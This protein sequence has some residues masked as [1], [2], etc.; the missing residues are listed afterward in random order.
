MAS[1]AEKRHTLAH[2]LAKAVLERH[3]NA[4]LTLG[5]AVDDGFYYDIDFGA[6]KISDADLPELEKAMRKHLPGWKEFSREEVSPD[7]AR[8]R[9]ANNPYKLEL[10]N[11][12]AARGE[13]VTLYTAGSTAQSSKLQAPSSSFTD[14]CRGGHAK[15]P[16]ADIAPDSFALDRIAGAYWR[17]DEAKPMLTRIYGLAFDTKEELDAYRAQR[18]EAKKR[19]HRKLGAELDLFVISELVG[20]GLPLFTPKGTLLRDL[21]SDF[22]WELNKAKGYEKVDIPH[23]AK[24]D[25]YKVSG[26]YDKYKDDGFQVHGRDK[27]FMLK[28]MNCPHH[29]QIYAS[30]ARSYRDLPIRYFD[31][32]KVYRDEQSG[33]LMGLSRV[34]SITQDDGHVFCR[35]DQIGE[36]VARVVSIIKDFYSAV[37]LLKEGSYRA[38]LSVRDPGTPEKYLGDPA[39]WDVAEKRLEEIGKEHGLALTRG[40]GEAAF[41]GPKLDFMFKDA[42]GRE[43][44]LATIQLDFVQPERFQLEYTDDTGSK[45]RPV[46]IHRAISGS[47]ERFLSVMIEHYA[48]AFPL[49]LSPE[50]VRVLPVSEKHAAY[51]AEVAAALMA[52]DIRAEADD[53]NESLGKKIR[54]GKQDKVPYLLVVGDKEAGAKTVTAESR[55][56]GKLEGLPLAALIER[57]AKEISE[58]A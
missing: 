57:L 19:D 58:R 55:D 49:W 46:M 21:I 33:E 32:T 39:V 8:T 27:H 52:A 11:E 15:H 42:I 18:E 22:L 35:P 9:F 51:A 36:E 53:A 20:A 43:W 1:L 24:P 45:A 17:G 48:G 5:P 47:L 40:E 38:R 34:L 4:L 54:A 23:L 14:L 56:H 12:I 29:T 30:R 13:P 37:G 10:V 7:E 16:A 26:H 28:P 3:P 25:L 50:Q 6:E 41:Y 44:Q 2:L 31:I